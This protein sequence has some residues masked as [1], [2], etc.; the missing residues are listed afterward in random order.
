MN[1]VSAYLDGGSISLIVA[2]IAS[3]VAGIGVYSRSI[4]RRISR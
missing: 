3:A 1:P 4:L 2:A